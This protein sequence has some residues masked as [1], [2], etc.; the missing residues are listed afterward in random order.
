MHKQIL[1]SGSNGVFEPLK[2]TTKLL[3]W[4]LKDLFGITFIKLKDQD[5]ISW[6]LEIWGFPF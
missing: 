3:Y 2:Q 4:R 6:M 1:L 5:D